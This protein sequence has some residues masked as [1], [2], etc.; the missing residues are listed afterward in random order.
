MKRS[1]YYYELSNEPIASI[2]MRVFEENRNNV[3]RTTL[4]RRFFIVFERAPS[5]PDD[6]ITCYVPYAGGHGE[7]VAAKI[8]EGLNAQEKV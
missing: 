2:E 3:E 4:T 1:T 6:F 7:E 5:E 8:V